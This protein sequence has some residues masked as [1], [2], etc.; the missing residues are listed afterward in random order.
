MVAPVHIEM[1]YN[2]WAIPSSAENVT[3]DKM[4]N[5]KKQLQEKKQRS[6]R[7]RK[8]KRKR[9]ILKNERNKYA[10]IIYVYIYTHINI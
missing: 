6:E 3:K 9:K 7:K 4:I 5:S 2:L 1:K 8:R 10:Q